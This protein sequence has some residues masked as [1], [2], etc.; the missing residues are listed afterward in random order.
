M[1]SK[2]IHVALKQII[3]SKG[4]TYADA[5]AVL[6]LSE[7]SVKRLFSSAGLSIQRLE[8]LCNWLGIDIKEVILDA[9]RHQPFIT[10]FTLEQEK[11]LTDNPRLLLV[12]Y[13]VLNNWKEREIKEEFDYTDAE[14]NKHFIKLEKI[15]F[16]VLFPFNRIRLLTA[17]NF[18]WSENGPVR[19]FFKQKILPDF[20]KTD[21]THPD[22]KM[23]FLGG[24]L[25]EGSI[26]KV[27]EK[28]DEFSQYFDQLIQNDL[29]LPVNKRHGVNMM[30]GFRR[31]MFAKILGVTRK[32]HNRHL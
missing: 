27:H 18:K 2:A 16:I 1:Q 25:S 13:L 9:E 7:G 10:Q 12:T 14:L 28:L 15:G 30:L 20:I 19:K 6:N 29:T 17:R 31:F 5:A 24:M 23:Y 32:T 11:E 22:E 8:T 3:R 4:K 26:M 21:F